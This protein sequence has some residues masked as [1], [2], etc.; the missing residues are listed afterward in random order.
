MPAGGHGER[1]SPVD[2]SFLQ[3]ES[4]CAH[5]HVA[6]TGIFSG[7]GAARP[8][9]DEIRARVS[10]RLTL[11]PRCRQRLLAAPL[12]LGEPRW[13]D[14]EQFDVAAH[15]V[16]LSEPSDAPGPSTFAAMRD[17][18]LS[19]PLDRERPLWQLAFVP[20]LADGR[21]A[22]I[23]RVHHAMADGAA[24]MQVALLA[25]DDDRDTVTPTPWRAAPAPTLLQRA[26]DPLA[27]NAELTS[28][29]AR[30]A[31][32]LATRPRSAGGAALRD[33][34]QLTAALTEDLLTRAPR[35]VLNRPLGSRR[36][37]V[38]HRVALD[39]VRAVSRGAAG[40]RHDV[41]IAAIA[42][43]LRA[44]ALEHGRPARPL[45][46][47]VPVNMRRPHDAMTPGNRVSMTS[48]WLPLDLASSGDR[49]QRV[50][51]QTARFK[52]SARP[53]GN[54]TLISGFGLLPNA[55]RA[56][57]LRTVAPGRFNLTIS[58]VPGPPRALFMHGMRLDEIYPVIPIAEGQSL[59]IGMLAYER[60][61]LFGLYADPDAF[62]DAAR[63][64]ELLDE[65][66]RDLRRGRSAPAVAPRAP[67]PVRAPSPVGTTPANRPAV[68][69]TTAGG[70]T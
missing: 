12:G 63:V 25:I 13:V 55:L 51:A 5:M 10:A 48:V 54:Q 3:L 4:S 30:D 59:S 39:D 17:A 57:V 47:M 62:G 49:L 14:D 22:M 31:V 65:E 24:A 37:L 27:R 41:C 9:I 68:L 50:R 34:R 46:A 66:L 20:R 19:R 28:R 40:T 26:L 18:L 44:H 6:W 29:A 2:A 60:Q 36:T 35:S 53:Q 32:R 70:P 15:V 45:K 67:R 1:L 64:A 58:S 56:P 69:T 21:L 11:V 38:Q 7:C 33:A 16:Q 43:A 8:T 52:H 23:G 61:M 42:G